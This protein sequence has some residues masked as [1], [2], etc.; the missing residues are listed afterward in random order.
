MHG[1]CINIHIQSNQSGNVQNKLTE[2]SEEDDIDDAENDFEIS[3]SEDSQS[4]D[5]VHE[6]RF[7]VH[8]P[9]TITERQHGVDIYDM[10]EAPIDSEQQNI[11]S[12][13]VQTILPGSKHH[14]EN[15]TEHERSES[16]IPTLPDLVLEKIIH[17]TIS[18]YPLMRYTLQRVSHSFERV[19]RKYGYPSI[20][21]RP[22]ESLN[23]PSIVSV[24]RLCRIYGSH[25]GLGLNLRRIL[26]AAGGRW[27]RAWLTLKMVENGWFEIR[28]V[29]WRI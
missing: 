28:D 5:D 1:S 2:S 16:Y 7:S 8:I 10:N 15:D 11:E 27:Y 12:V 13:D 9:T 19:V 26:H 22:G 14:N 4:T 17:I 29:N 20:Y 24:A 21:L 6:S 23:M 18:K 25:S 3:I